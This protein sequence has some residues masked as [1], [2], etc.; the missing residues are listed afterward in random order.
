MKN[1][2]VRQE[3]MK[4]LEEK[5]GKNLSDLSCNNF[6]LDTSPKARELKA[7]MNYW[8]LMKIKSFCTAKETINKTK[9]QPME[10]E[11]IS[12]NDLS[13]KALVSK[14]YRELTKLNT[15]KTN[16]PVKKWA[17]DM[18]RHFPKKTSRW[19]TDTWKDA[20]Y[21]SS[22]GNY[23]SKP[24]WDTTSHQSEWLKWTT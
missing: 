6:L 5:A 13:D 19:P 11:E 22:S 21:H 10:W 24:H 20:R 9:R 4:I 8:D 15:W 12:A 23:K 3:T 16:N 1:L 18:N 17:E 2:N 7:K 14:I